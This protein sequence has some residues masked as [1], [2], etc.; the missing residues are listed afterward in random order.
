MPKKSL[1]M[2]PEIMQRSTVHRIENEDKEG[3]ETDKKRCIHLVIFGGNFFTFS[4]I[5]N[6]PLRFFLRS[7]ALQ[8]QQNALIQELD[9]KATR[10]ILQCR[11]D[12]AN[13]SECIV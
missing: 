12:A 5:A 10:L 3:W 8:D 7:P 2:S 13:V 1:E 11:F 4:S 6:P 9:T